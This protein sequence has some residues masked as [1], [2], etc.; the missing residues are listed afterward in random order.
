M[1][2]C[3]PIQAGR[4]RAWDSSKVFAAIVHKVETGEQCVSKPALGGGEANVTR[5][6]IVAQVAFNQASYLCTLGK[7]PCKFVIARLL[8]DPYYFSQV[9]T[10]V[11]GKG[12]YRTEAEVQALY[13]GTAGKDHFVTWQQEVIERKAAQDGCRCHTGVVQQVFRV[14]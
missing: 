3:R 4:G 5:I 2:V 6:T 9:C 7:N 1:L 12:L 8:L 10:G 11:R 13:G 14:N